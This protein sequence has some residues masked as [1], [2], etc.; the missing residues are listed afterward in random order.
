MCG[1]NIVWFEVYFFSEKIY[2]NIIIF[3]KVII[4][5]LWTNFIHKFKVLIGL[6]FEFQIIFKSYISLFNESNALIFT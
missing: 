6:L 2:E 5:S 3:R 1:Q 4:E